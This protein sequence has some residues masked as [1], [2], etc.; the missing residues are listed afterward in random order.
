MPRLISNT[1][2]EISGRGNM[3]KTQTIFH[4][5]PRCSAK[6][7]IMKVAEVNE[8]FGFRN[9]AKPTDKKRIDRPQS[10][11]RLCRS[12]HARVV[13]EFKASNKKLAN[14]DLRSHR[15]GKK[16]KKKSNFS[17]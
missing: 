7:N 11:C 9:M 6:A 2:I 12:A 1:Y 4:N 14:V 13:R 17:F 15:I 10:L 3:T 8:V 16:K 5:C